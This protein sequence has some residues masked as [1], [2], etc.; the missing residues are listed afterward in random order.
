MSGS[1]SLHDLE[2]PLVPLPVLFDCKYQK[3]LENQVSASLQNPYPD[4]RAFYQDPVPLP[5]GSLQ[6]ARNIFR[7]QSHLPRVQASCREAFC[8]NFSARCCSRCGAG[9]RRAASPH[10][11]SL[12]APGPAM[13]GDV[14]W[15]KQRRPPSWF[16]RIQMGT[17]SP[18]DVGR[19]GGPPLPPCLAHRTSLP[20]D[21]MKAD[22]GS[23]AA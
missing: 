6:S 3:G 2:W 12:P 9:S 7:R 22:G 4:P 11:P 1:P 10:S 21:G 14:L 15:A 8:W 23:A 17:E 5:P 18:R 16:T 20:S 19:A 13:R